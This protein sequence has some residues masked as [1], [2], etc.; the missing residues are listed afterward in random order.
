MAR[1][2]EYNFEMCK[3]ICSE[4]AGGFNIKTILKSKDEYPTFQ[5]WC[6]WKR[7]HDELFDLYVKAMQDKSESELEEI[8]YIRDM[9]KS[10]DIEPSSANVLIQTSK[11]LASKFYPKMFGDKTDITSG[12][13]KI[14][15]A[16][17]AINVR[18]IE[19]NN[20]E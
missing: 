16:P 1:P 4:V 3:V 9:L 6:N 2:S 10:G 14:Q 7:E 13:E 11:W 18:I 17:S 15:S 8:D 20:D 12:G 19:N 5:T